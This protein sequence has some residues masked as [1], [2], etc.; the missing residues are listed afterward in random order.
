M[1]CFIFLKLSL[2]L[3]NSVDPDEMQ[4]YAAFHLGLYCLQKYS[5]RGF[6]NMKGKFLISLPKLHWELGSGG[7]TMRIHIWAITWQNQKMRRPPPPLLTPFK[8][9]IINFGFPTSCAILQLIRMYHVDE[10]WC[11]SWSAC[12]TVF[13]EWCKI[14][15]KN[16]NSKTCVKRPLSKRPKIGFKTNYRLVQVKSIAECSRGAFCNTFGLD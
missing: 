13:R 10:K 3:T 9:Y 1:L 14:E 15:K 11:W 5:F 2:T 7:L 8:C 4:H 6:T 12:Y 16:N